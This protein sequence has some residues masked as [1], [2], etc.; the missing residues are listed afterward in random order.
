MLLVVLALVPVF[1]L[2]LVPQRKDEGPCADDETRDDDGDFDCDSHSD[3]KIC[4]D[5]DDDSDFEPGTVYCSV[6]R[7]SLQRV[8]PSSPA[9]TPTGPGTASGC[10]CRHHADSIAESTFLTHMKRAVGLRC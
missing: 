8:L 1:V 9:S 3:D 5:D 2:V 7:L 6:R 4:D 10:V